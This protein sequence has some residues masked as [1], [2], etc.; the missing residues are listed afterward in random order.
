MPRLLS[1]K[2]NFTAGE[3]TPRAFGRGDLRGYENGA[4]RLR[5]VFIHP[6]GGLFRRPGLAFVAG[7]PGTGRL[8]PFEFNT[9]QTYLLVL[10]HQ[11]I[12]VY[13]DDAL[14]ATLVAPWTAAQ[15]KDLVWTQSADTLFLCH[16]EVR[17]RRLVREGE[18]DFALAD[19]AFREKDGVIRQPLFRFTPDGVTLQANA[20]TGNVTLTASAALFASGHVGARFR[21]K[22]KEVVITAVAAPTSATAE[23]RQTLVDTAATDDYLEQAFSAVRGWPAS[24]TF[25]QDRLVLG[26]SRDLPNRLW[27]SRIGVFEDFDLGTG[28]DDEAIEFALLSDQVNAVT[29]VFSGRHLQVFT[30]GGE[31]AVTGEPLT[32]ARVQA[33]RQ[34]RIGS[35]P[36]RRVPPRSVDGATLFL[37]RSGRE[38][39]EFVYTDIEQAYQAGDLATLAQHVFD[40]PLDQD[41]DADDRLFHVAMSSGLL[42]S[43]TVF[44]AEEV[45]AWTVQETDGAFEAVAVVGGETYVLVRRGEARMIERFDKSLGT[46]AAL[47]GES[48]TPKTTWSGLDH[49]E[50][51]TAT[52][53]ADGMPQAP[54]VV[55]DGAVTLDRPALRVE[56]GLGFTHVIEPLPPV[57]GAAGAGATQVMPARLVRAIFRLVE[58]S[59]LRVDVGLGPRD[60]PFGRLGEGLLDAP[61]APFTGDK[62]VRGLG[63]VRGLTRPLWRIEQASPL[64]MQLLSV[65]TELMVSD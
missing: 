31:W 47:V 16:P 62:A 34:T 21:L 30:T 9:E 43:L 27:M 60:L 17:A 48:A 3:I 38:L 19:F 18:A 36:D 41:F 33:R 28:L 14:V 22:D 20:T 25:H 13:A 23:V 51:R 59:A 32:P 15:L 57:V 12:E 61:P 4:A 40:R 64:P 56:V 52:V 53:I 58:T 65:T 49:L 6:T 42:A 26:G 7:A 29:A 5:N 45:T 37:A 1:V 10:T 11:K 50:G 55:A 46:D 44:R 35:L 54:C 39:R 8:L 24:A 63:W 2:T